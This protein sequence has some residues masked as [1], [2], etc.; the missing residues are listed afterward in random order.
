MSK[1]INPSDVAS[2]V[3]AVLAQLGYSVADDA[4][5][6]V[7]QSTSQPRATSHKGQTAPVAVPL[8][9]SAFTSAPTPAP[10][11]HDTSRK[12]P[13]GLHALIGGEKDSRIK[14]PKGLFQ[15]GYS[16][17]VLVFDDGHEEA[18]SEDTEGRG[19]ISRKVACEHSN[20]S[21]GQYLSFAPRGDG[22]FDVSVSNGQAVA[23][24]A[25]TSRKARK[26]PAQTEKP[27]QAGARCVT[28]GGPGIIG[29][30]VQSV[31]GTAG[32]AHKKCMAQAVAASKGKV[33]P[34]YASGNAPG[35][36]AP[37]RNIGANQ[38]QF[39]GIV[40]PVAVPLPVRK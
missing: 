7:A 26:A 15:T 24:N 14:L 13:D 27:K 38:K 12:G 21:E 22:Y 1:T 20:A 6:R 16:T 5:A 28:C 23:A 2:I 32:Y 3:A 10:V 31:A 8:P 37:A 25:S 9:G 4:S 30:T 35:R 36:P 39:A 11:A 40:A 29:K 34:I 18:I 17:V 19:R 33:A